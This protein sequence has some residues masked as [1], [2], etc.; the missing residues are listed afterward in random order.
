MAIHQRVVEKGFTPNIMAMSTQLAMYA[1]HI[2]DKKC[3]AWIFL[4]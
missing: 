1:K 2:Q 3:L 4:E